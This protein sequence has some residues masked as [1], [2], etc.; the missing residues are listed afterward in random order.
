MF[1][2]VQ[3]LHNCAHLQNRFL[4]LGHGLFIL[5]NPLRVRASFLLFIIFN[6]LLHE[7][8]FVKM[9]FHILEL[10]SF[11]LASLLQQIDDGLL[12]F[13]QLHF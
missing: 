9:I 10:V 5:R 13:M 12:L 6:L 11:L 7:I 4:I 1:R 8:I 2:N 3:V